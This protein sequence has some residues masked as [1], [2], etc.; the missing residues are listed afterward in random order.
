M[1]AEHPGPISFAKVLSEIE[2]PAGLSGPTARLA[3]DAVL[4]GN[5]SEAQI[6]GLLIGLR[7]RPE[8]S[9]V[10]A[11]A[12]EAM[13][14]TMVRV[15]HS[16]AQVLDTCGTGGDGQGTLN[17]ST[18]AAIVVAAAGHVVAKHGNR[19]VSSRSGSADVLA[20]LGI[21]LDLDVHQSA[22][23]LREV[24]IS[25][26]LA[27]N[28]HP[29]M[30]F[31][32]PVRRTLGV[33]TVFNCLGPMANPARATH[34]LVGAYSDEIRPLLAETLAKTGSV[35]VWV[36]CGA[37][38]L[39]EVSPFGPTHV[40]ESNRGVL[41]EFEVVPEDFGLKRS[42]AGAIA[43]GN[44]EEN[45]LQLEAIIANQP[46]SARDAVILNAAAA[47]VI[48][49]DLAPT[50]A[51]QKAEQLIAGGAALNKLNEWRRVAQSKKT[52]S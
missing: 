11:A 45:A 48:A 30:R 19:A 20:A 49:E 24:G 1:T 3:F 13:R 37:D 36:V 16:F 26:L 46:H 34:Q 6:A 40:T 2:S 7:L 38:G 21:P 14:A 52:H 10:L 44:A 17:I 18:T 12:V 29:A 42:P 43:G 9:D 50:S 22:E 31:A 25:F 39:D 8:N 15:E 28:H 33:R 41:R 23:I 47:L 27:P 35:R 51:A 5:W 32:M 4:S